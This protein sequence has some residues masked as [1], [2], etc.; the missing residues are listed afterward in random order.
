MS[1]AKIILEGTSG[2]STRKRS[3]VKH[4]DVNEGIITVGKK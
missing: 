2:I 3:W 4:T 1:Q